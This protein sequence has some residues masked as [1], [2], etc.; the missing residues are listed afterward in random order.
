[1][2]LS[3]VII[4]F[5]EEANIESCLKSL[6]EIADEIIVVD[7]F[8]EDKTQDICLKLGVR[9][10]Q[11]E[12]R[13]FSNAKNYGNSLAN[14]DYIIS[15]DADEV[16]SDKLKQSI[17]NVKNELQGAYSFNRLT[18]YVG[19][20]VRH[21]GWYPDAKVRIF[22]KNKA[23]WKG[24][25]VHEI[26]ELDE[27]VPSTQLKGDL[28]HYSYHSVAQH[29]MRIEKYSNLHAQQMFDDGK[30]S[31]PLKL[32]FAPAFKFFKDYVLKLGFLDGKTG[33]VICR[34]SAKAVY[35]KYKKLRKLHINQV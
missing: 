24:N 16:V 34:I 25:Y 5:N 13:G 23:K 1:M 35:L 14:A 29:Y 4:T 9:F 11:K 22:P 30:Q 33:F 18:N 10:Y 7:S 19:K 15:L 21:C 17:L 20:W 6:L 12:W 27:N 2:K 3:A 31:S 26:L 8:S 28:L 32:L